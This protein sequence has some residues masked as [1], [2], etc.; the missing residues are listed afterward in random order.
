[1][2]GCAIFGTMWNAYGSGSSSY[3]HHKPRGIPVLS[4]RRGLTSPLNLFT[5]ICNA[6]LFVSA[7]KL[8]AGPSDA[9]SSAFLNWTITCGTYRSSSV[10]AMVFW[11]DR[12]C[13]LLSFWRLGGGRRVAIL[14][15]VELKLNRKGWQDG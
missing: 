4:G 13:E 10:D 12:G 15:S 14:G 6:S 3:E 8:I 11:T 5:S 9:P 7:G 1:M 2:R